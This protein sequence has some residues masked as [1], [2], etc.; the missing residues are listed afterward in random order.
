MVAYGCRDKMPHE[1][2]ILHE[3]GIIKV[4]V[5]IRCNVKKRYNKKYKQRIDNLA[6]LKDHIRQFAQPNGKTKRIYNQ[7][8]KHSLMTIKI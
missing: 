6:Y 8:Y 2:K 1:F 5:C 7:I 4:E 3:T